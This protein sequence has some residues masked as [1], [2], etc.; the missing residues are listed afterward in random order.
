MS[1][2]SIETSPTTITS[3]P[4]DRATPDRN[5]YTVLHRV[6]SVEV[7]CQIDHSVIGRMEWV[8]RVRLPKQRTERIA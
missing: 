6:I 8:T 1:R 4:R 3:D 2:G 7:E 5:L